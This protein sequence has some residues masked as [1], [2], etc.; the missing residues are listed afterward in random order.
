M[1]S[2]TRCSTAR[3][4]ALSLQSAV[5]LDIKVGKNTAVLPR[6]SA[7]LYKIRERTDNSLYST[8][9]KFWEGAA[10]KS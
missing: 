1:P 2:S 5:F 8:G 7:A 4:A 3:L 6:L 9:E 10:H